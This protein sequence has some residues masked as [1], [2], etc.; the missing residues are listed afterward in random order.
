[1][2]DFRTVD[3]VMQ[4]FMAFP[5]VFKRLKKFSPGISFFVKYQLFYS[6]E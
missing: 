3:Q 6:D 5:V 2:M 1:M 4:H